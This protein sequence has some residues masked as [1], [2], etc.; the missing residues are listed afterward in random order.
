MRIIRGRAAGATS[1]LRSDTFAG[2]VWADP[3]L[4]VID[5]TTINVV[6]F[7]PGARTDWHEHT[8]GQ[9]L[10][11][12]TGEGWVCAAGG[13]AHRLLPGDTVWVLPGERHWHGATATTVM[14]HTAISLGPT[15]WYDEVGPGGYAAAHDEES[16]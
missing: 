4:P 15:H 7:T 14:T 16:R 1:T 10:Q 9:I 6:T 3:V 13:P 12:L 2:T 5:G 8:G 11:V